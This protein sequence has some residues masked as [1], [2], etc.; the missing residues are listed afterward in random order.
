MSKK[1]EVRKLG[2]KRK[3][4]EEKEGR[5]ERERK[6][7]MHFSQEHQDTIFLDLILLRSQCRVS[8][9]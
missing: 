7:D 1:K 8:S 5:E 6:A 9:Q 4:D 2:Q 3:E